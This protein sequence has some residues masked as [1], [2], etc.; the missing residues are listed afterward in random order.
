MRLHTVWGMAASHPGATH[1][2][3]YIT[4]DAP[5]VPRVTTAQPAATCSLC[6][7]VLINVLLPLPAAL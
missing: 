2:T 7:V 4:A 3:R 1:T 5:P 6:K